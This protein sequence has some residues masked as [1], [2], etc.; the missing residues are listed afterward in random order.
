MMFTICKRIVFEPE[1][2]IL[3]GLYVD[4]LSKVFR[5]LL[6][7]QSGNEI[8]RGRNHIIVELRTT[9]YGQFSI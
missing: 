7:L 5:I 3:I 2:F 9:V 8:I 6:H 1:D 4:E